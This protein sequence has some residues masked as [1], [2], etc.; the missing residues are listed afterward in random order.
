MNILETRQMHSFYFILFHIMQWKIPS[1]TWNWNNSNKKKKKNQASKA[2]KHRKKNPIRYYG[3]KC[4]YKNVMEIFHCR[5]IWMYIFI[6][7]HIYEKKYPTS[8]KE[9]NVLI[10]IYFFLL[11][12]FFIAPVNC[13][14]CRTLSPGWSRYSLDRDRLGFN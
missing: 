14:T 2:T 10:N 3:Y 8:N 12:I 4:I 11:Y 6:Y 1:I 13:K 9:V 5:Y 7:I